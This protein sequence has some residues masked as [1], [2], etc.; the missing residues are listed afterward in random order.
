MP[1][2][3]DLIAEG[4]KLLADV[5]LDSWIVGSLASGGGNYFGTAP[6]DPGAAE[7]LGEAAHAELIVWMRNNLPALLDALEAAQKKAEWEAWAN[8]DLAPALDAARSRIAELE[9]AQRPPLGYTVT[10]VHRGR[11]AVR[12]AAEPDRKRSGRR[13]FAARR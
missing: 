3:R 1:A 6:D 2:D 12:D 5:G 7:L 8:D 9:A 11:C 4:R 13:C 10:R